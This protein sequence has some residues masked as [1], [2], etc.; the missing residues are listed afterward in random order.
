MR[1]AQKEDGGPFGGRQQRAVVPLLVLAAFWTLNSGCGKL[2]SQAE[3][4][5][6]ASGAPAPSE[7]TA[8]EEVRTRVV[9]PGGPGKIAFVSDRDGQPDIY[10]MDP[11]GSNVRRVTN[12]PLTEGGPTWSPDGARLAFARDESHREEHVTYPH[13]DSTQHSVRV[14][15]VGGWQVWVINTDGTNPV[16]LT[17]GDEDTAEPAWSPNGGKI[18][19]VHNRD[20]WVMNPDGSDAK[21][22][23]PPLLDTHLERGSPAWSPDGKQLVFSSREGDPEPLAQRP[24]SEIWVANADGSN[25]TKIPVA[26]HG[27]ASLLGRPSWSPDGATIAYLDIGSPY[28][29]S[30]DGSNGRRLPP[31]LDQL[32]PCAGWSDSSRLSWSPDGQRIIFSA[33]QVSYGADPESI[34]HGVRAHVGDSEIWGIHADGNGLVNLTN[35][36][37]DD[38]DPAWSLR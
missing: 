5:K 10:V 32:S 29:A 17:S 24:W 35:N 27:S 18:A 11:D 23:F 20:I 4:E 26:W 15:R 2:A 38:R 36:P 37:A 14:E 12:D 34:W 22:L 3:G 9:L 31:P 6:P 8:G 19:F 13:P 33:K 21:P 16:R 25:R 28:L 1:I 7:T 30:P